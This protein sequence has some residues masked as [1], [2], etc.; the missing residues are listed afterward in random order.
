M[1]SGGAAHQASVPYKEALM[2][3]C[4]PQGGELRCTTIDEMKCDRAVASGES[5]IALR[6]IQWESRAFKQHAV[7]NMVSPVMVYKCA[8][9]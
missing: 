7:F 9:K 2:T 5:M 6:S 4:A 1:R 8:R 3:S